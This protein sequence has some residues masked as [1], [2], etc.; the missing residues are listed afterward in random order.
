[1]SCRGCHVKALRCLFTIIARTLA[2][3]LSIELAFRILLSPL[4]RLIQSNRDELRLKQR[5]NFQMS[6]C[7]RTVEH[8][9]ISRAAQRMPIHR[10]DK[11]G[12]LFSGRRSLFSS[13]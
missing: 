4:V 13:Y 1:M 3:D 2:G 6:K 7:R 8:A 5:D 11:D 12:L 10:P 9:I